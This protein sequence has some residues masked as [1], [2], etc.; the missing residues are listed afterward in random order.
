MTKCA[1][2]IQ[3]QACKNETFTKETFG[4]EPT[5]AK[6]TLGN[7]EACFMSINRTVDGSY[8]TVSFNYTDPYVLVFD[9]I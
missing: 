2:Q 5:S 6:V 4:A 3:N 8:G 1:K 9:P 7:G